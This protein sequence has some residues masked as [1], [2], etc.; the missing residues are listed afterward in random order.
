[1]LF[2]VS[3]NFG[4]INSCCVGFGWKVFCFS[5]VVVVRKV[6]GEFGVCFWGKSSYG[7][8]Y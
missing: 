3:G 5:V 1:M 7:V 8:V 2:L 6:F 4:D